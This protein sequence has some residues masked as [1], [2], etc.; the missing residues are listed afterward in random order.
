[1]RVTR[2]QVQDSLPQLSSGQIEGVLPLP[3]G[4]HDALQ[5]DGF[6]GVRWELD[7]VGTRHDTGQVA[8]SRRAKGGAVPQ[9]GTASRRAAWRPSQG[10]RAGICQ[11]AGVLANHSQPA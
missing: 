2:S 1:M 9:H 11:S 4:I 6:G 5:H 3:D 7:V 10:P 8:I